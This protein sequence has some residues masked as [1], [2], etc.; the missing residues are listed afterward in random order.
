MNI[1]A[2]FIAG[3]KFSVADNFHYVCN[4]LDWLSGANIP[5]RMVK[6]VERKSI[7]STSVYLYCILKLLGM[8]FY[9]FDKK[10]KC[11][12][13][14]CWH[15]LGISMA[16]IYW[17]I[18]SLLHS[19]T[20]I[21]YSSG[22]KFEVIEGIW[23]RVFEFQIFSS[24]PIILFNFIK[25]KHVQNFL[26]NIEKFDTQM[27]FL[28]WKNDVEFSKVIELLPIVPIIVVICNYF[29]LI[30]FD[31]SEMV[32][33]YKPYIYH[34]RFTAYLIMMEMFFVISFIF[35]VSCLCISKRFKSLTENLK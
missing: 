30:Y 6:A 18:Q 2:H 29:A 3:W 25:R 11:F 26:R 12:K 19:K 7:Y 14:S 13:V 4:P 16:V 8:A 28:E 27:E 24:I 17:I 23:R 35:I 1:L 31:L 34:I 33:L 15:Y 20:E 5:F 32:Y 21:N 10:L 9:A 22:L